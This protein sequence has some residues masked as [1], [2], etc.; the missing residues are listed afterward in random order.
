MY[1]ERWAVTDHTQYLFTVN[2]GSNTLSVFHIPK[3]DP[4]HPQ[5]LC[6]PVDTLGDFP[7]AVAYSP[8]HKTGT[9]SMKNVV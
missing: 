3:D 6:S 7:Q 1:T 5:L 2:A 9:T 4:E 8:L